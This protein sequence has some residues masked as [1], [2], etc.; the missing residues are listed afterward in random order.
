MS[1][2]QAARELK[3]MKELNADMQKVIDVFGDKCPLF[4]EFTERERDLCALTVAVEGKFVHCRYTWTGTGFG[5]RSFHL[6][7]SVEEY[8]FERFCVVMFGKPVQDTA[9]RKLSE[10]VKVD[11]DFDK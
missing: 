8:I 9:K 6:S 2:A 5:T 7:G 3:S 10:P 11:A 4:K 1:A